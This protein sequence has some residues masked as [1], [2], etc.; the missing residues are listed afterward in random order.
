MMLYDGIPSEA[1]DHGRMIRSGED[2][3]SARITHEWVALRPERLV[4]VSSPERNSL[5]LTPLSCRLLH[6]RRD[7][8]RLESVDSRLRS[9][10]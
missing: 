10:G 7:R 9:A 3:E 5:S 6:D 2:A 4:S 1:R 8:V